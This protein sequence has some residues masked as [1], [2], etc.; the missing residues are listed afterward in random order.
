LMLRLERRGIA[1]RQG[2][3]APVATGYYSRKYGLR[4]EDFP[5][6]LLA[7]RLSVALPLY[8]G[9][10]DAEQD[11]VVEELLAAHEED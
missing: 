1:T 5:A 3:H 10:S 6:A 2:T 8:P 11:L 9:M 4:E 7:E